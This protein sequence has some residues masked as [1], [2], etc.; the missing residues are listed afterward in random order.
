MHVRKQAM[1]EC[2]DGR[3]RILH[4][5]THDAMSAFSGVRDASARMKGR[6]SHLLLKLVQLRTCSGAGGAF[7]QADGAVAQ[8]QRDP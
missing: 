8:W 1:A 6:R 2:E 3:P 4:T 7:I 5:S